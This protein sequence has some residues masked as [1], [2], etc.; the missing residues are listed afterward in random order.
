[1]IMDYLVVGAGFSGV[2]LAERIASQLNKKVLLIDRRNHIGGNCYDYYNDDGILVHKYGP[3][4][5]R[6]NDQGVWDYLSK[7]T[8]WRHV[9]YKVLAC[10]DGQYYNFPINLDTFNNLFGLSLNSEQMAERLKELSVG[11]DEINNSRDVIISKVG[12]ELYE[13]FYKN[14]TKKQWGMGPEE[15]DPSVCAR[16]PIRTNRDDRYLNDEYQAMPKD[17]Y[18]KLFERMLDHPNIEVRLNTEYEEVKNECKFLGTIYTGPVDEF[19]GYKY[20]R[21]P[22]RSLRFEHETLDQEFYQPVSQVNYPNEHDYTRIVEIKHVTGQKHPQTTIVK[23]FPVAEG[24]PYY[25]VPRAENEVLCQKYLAAEEDLTD[26]FLTGR[27]ARY[28]YLNMDQVVSSAL[29]LFEERIKPSL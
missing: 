7:F 26:T 22:Y 11:C 6:T 23:E 10:V 18:H 24:D 29:Q 9:Q 15:L 3:H 2:T 28:R 5:F 12:E 17:G 13:K 16:I 14:Y 25:P 4:Y 1:M 20:G 21:L 27:L 19:F 8:G